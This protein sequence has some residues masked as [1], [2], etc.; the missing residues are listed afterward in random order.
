M[1]IFVL[2]LIVYLEYIPVM[3]YLLNPKG[4]CPIKFHCTEKTIIKHGKDLFIYI[5]TH[6]VESTRNLA[7]CSDQFFTCDDQSKIWSIDKPE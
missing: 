7:S 6:S 3:F 4:Q 5:F 1:K 2:L